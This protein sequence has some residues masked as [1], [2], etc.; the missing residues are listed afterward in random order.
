MPK[1]I[2]LTPSLNLRIMG[3]G[4]AMKAG[5]VQ[6]QFD[7]RARGTS[8]QRAK[9]AGKMNPCTGA[10]IIR[11]HMQLPRQFL[12]NWCVLD[13]IRVRDPTLK[14]I[15]IL[16]PAILYIF[17]RNSAKDQTQEVF[18]TWCADMK[19]PNPTFSVCHCIDLQDGHRKCAMRHES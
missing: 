9:T 3:Q 18:S 8:S 1:G 4:Q 17:C 11:R 19:I 14:Y 2:N 6:A 15:D 16:P 10:A 13:I 5:L 7:S 12:P